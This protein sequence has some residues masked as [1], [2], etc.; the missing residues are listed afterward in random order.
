MVFAV[1]HQPLLQHQYDLFSLLLYEKCLLPQQAFSVPFPSQ[2]FISYLKTSAVCVCVFVFCISLCNLFWPCEDASHFV[3]NAC[4]DTKLKVHWCSAAAELRA[5]GPG[6][7]SE[8]QQLQG[9]LK[10]EPLK[11]PL[12]KPGL[13]LKVKV[14]YYLWVLILAPTFVQ[15]H[16]SCTLWRADNDP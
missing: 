10:D 12:R 15:Q 8:L 6:A 16:Q 13:I 14:N 11:F 7:T 9:L 1:R 4:D 5:R 3:Q 2:K